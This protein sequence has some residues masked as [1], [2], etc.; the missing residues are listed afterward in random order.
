MKLIIKSGESAENA[1]SFLQ[2]FLSQYRQNYPVLKGDMIVF[3]T[4][5]DC[6]HRICPDNREEYILT[7]EEIVDVETRLRQESFDKVISWWKEFV[8]SKQEIVSKVEKILIADI[9]YLK[10]AE[11]KKRRKDLIENRLKKKERNQ[12]LLQQ[13]TETYNYVLLLDDMFR[14]GNFST[15]YLKQTHRGKPYGYDLD[16]YIVFQ[17]MDGSIWHFGKYGLHK[18]FPDQRQN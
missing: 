7:S 12:V 6:E 9:R 4:L 16:C 18:G 13:V 8:V 10:A 14:N 5:E 1:V 2:E 17:S 3:I 11:E 15:V